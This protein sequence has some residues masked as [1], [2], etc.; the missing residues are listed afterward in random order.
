MTR[1]CW[2]WRLPP[3]CAA[4][5]RLRGRCAAPRRIMV[6]GEGEA[7]AKP[8][9]AMLSLSVMREAMTAREALTPTTRRWPT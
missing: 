1:Y 3:R 8:D 7:T 9:I 6:L 2:R 5:G 4:R